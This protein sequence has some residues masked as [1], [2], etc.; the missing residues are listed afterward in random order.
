MTDMKKESLGK[1]L[2]R[3]FLRALPLMGL[4]AMALWLW[5]SGEKPSVDMIKQA[6]QTYTD[7]KP[8][9]VALFMLLLF[10]LKSV[11]LMFPI[12]VLMGACGALFPLPAAILIATLGTALTLTIPYLI[13]R[14][15]GPDMT[16]KLQ[17]KYERL[18]EL[19]ALR[20]RN[21]FFLAFLIRIIGILPCDVVSLYLGNTRMPYGKYVVGGVLGFLAD[22]L[23]ATVVGMKAEDRSSPWF[24]GAIA[25]NLLV[26][27]GSTL[28]Y[29]Y[30]R[31][32][33]ADED[34]PETAGTEEAER[35]ETTEETDRTE[36][37][38]R[39]EETERP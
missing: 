7:D 18:R 13:G 16:V 10:A 35:P 19:R 22:I 8:L 33:H 28:F 11:S 30:Y 23:T 14:G 17:Q 6:V 20:R 1:R 15:A 36:R 32:R 25:V 21:E 5:L 3:L 29:T 34:A 38:D 39:T 26:A 9:M 12:L 24:W 37:T 2:G 27:A 31:K 4:T